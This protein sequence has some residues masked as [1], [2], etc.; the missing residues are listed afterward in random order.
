MLAAKNDKRSTVRLLLAKGANPN[1]VTI[2]G[3]TARDIAKKQGHS[4]VVDILTK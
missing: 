2:K 4:Y 1:A 3:N